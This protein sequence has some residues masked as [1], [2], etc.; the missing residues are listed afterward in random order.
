MPR[1]DPQVNI[2]QTPDRFAILEAAAFVEGKTPSRLV[3]ELVDEAV[4]RYAD[5]TP[6]KGALKAR[7]EH[8][9]A[10]EGKLRYLE[11]PTQSA[12]ASSGD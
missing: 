9:A 2:R 6:V 12:P 8:A 5:M 1:N 11:T 3:Q 10:K 4:E 7:A